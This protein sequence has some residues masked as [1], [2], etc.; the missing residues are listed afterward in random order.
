MKLSNKIGLLFVLL[1]LLFWNPFTRKVIIFILPLGRGIDDL[2]FWI[3][4]VL[5]LIWAFVKS[6]ISV[7][8]ILKRIDKEK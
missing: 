7:P 3:F 8:K 2:V 6:F 1:V 4:L 5:F